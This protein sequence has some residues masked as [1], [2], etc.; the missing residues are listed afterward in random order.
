MN[1]NPA[2]QAHELLYCLNKVSVRA[3]VSAE[4]F[5]TQKYYDI[6]CEIMPEIPTCNA[7][8]VKSAAVPSLEKI[9]MMTDHDHE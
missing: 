1:I 7:G 4:A 9:I 2:Y 8:E 6:M 5:K 3:I